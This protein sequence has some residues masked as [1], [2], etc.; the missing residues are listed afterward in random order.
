ML[1]SFRLSVLNRKL[2]NEKRIVQIQQQKLQ[3]SENRFRTMA[4]TAPVLIWIS[5]ADKQFTYFNKS[6]LEFTGRTVDQEAGNGWM[7]GV[8]P[9]DMQRCVETY[10]NNHEARK[11]FS[12]EYRLR[13]FDGEY[14]WLIDNGVPR[15][16]TQ[17]I[18]QGYIGS[19]VDIT[20]RKQA[21]KALQ[22]SHESL[23]QILDSMNGLVYVVDMK[24]YETLYINK[25]GKEI[26][27]DFTGKVCWQNLQFCQ[28]GPCSFCTTNNLLKQDASSA[29]VHVWEFQNSATGQWYE[30]RDSAIVWPDGRLVKMEMATDITGRKLLQLERERMITELQ[31][32][33]AEV[34]TLSGIIPICANCKKVRDD[35]GYWEQ[36]ESYVTHHTSAQF[37]HAICPDCVDVLYPKQAE[38]IR[39]KAKE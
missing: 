5:G 36:V 37:S 9:D 34:K 38:R 39:N 30:G 29:R 16:D 27:G 25:Y 10:A 33:I 8:H 22:Q 11:I 7:A 6:W 20:E 23:H 2:E 18:F 17:G 31:S 26:W 12:M 21:E 28:N 13:R 14:R 3:E 4:D 19:C 32:A 15:F 35:K 1:L 24:S